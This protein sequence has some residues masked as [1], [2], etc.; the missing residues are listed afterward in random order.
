MK[1]TALTYSLYIMHMIE[2]ILAI[3]KCYYYKNRK[4][5]KLTSKHT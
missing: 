3:N 2:E 5:T 1:T 4:N